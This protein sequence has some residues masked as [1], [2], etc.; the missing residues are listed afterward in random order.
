MTRQTRPQVMT[1]MTLIRLRTV[2]I[3]VD[4]A[5]IRN[6]GKGPDQIMRNFDGKI[7]DDSI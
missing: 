3:D 2:I 5:R 6:T 4:D 7:D 1:L